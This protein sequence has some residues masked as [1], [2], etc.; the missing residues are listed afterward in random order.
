MMATPRYPN[1]IFAKG[2]LFMPPGNDPPLRG[3]GSNAHS[4]PFSVNI[5]VCGKRIKIN[6]SILGR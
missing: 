3:P 1:A 6:V 4:C 2:K 5:L